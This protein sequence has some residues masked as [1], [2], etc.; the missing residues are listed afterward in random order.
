MSEEKIKNYQKEI[1]ILKSRN[2]ED[3][4]IN[5]KKIKEYMNEIEQLKD[6]EKQNKLNN[7]KII[8]NLVKMDG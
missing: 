2:K 6:N 3:N 7:E 1:D 8:K 5:I 4:D